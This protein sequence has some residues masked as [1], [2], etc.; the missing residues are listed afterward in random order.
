MAFNFSGS[1]TNQ[2]AKGGFSFGSNSSA[3]GGDNDP[4]K[5]VEYT[6][7][8]NSDAAS[9]FEALQSAFKDKTEDNG[10]ADRAKAEAKRFRNATDSEFWFAV[11]FKTREEKEAFLKALKISKR[12]MGDKYIDGHKLAKMLDIE[13]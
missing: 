12:L 9:E 2:P 4:L 10:A 1:N 5:D 7:D 3:F 6:D 8:L 11:C 13:L